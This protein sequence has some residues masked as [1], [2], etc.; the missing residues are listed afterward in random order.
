[1]PP[2]LCCHAAGNP[3]QPS[4][5]DT[6]SP[7]GTSTGAPPIL[8]TDGTLPGSPAIVLHTSLGVSQVP[9]G[10][11]F[12]LQGFLVLDKQAEIAAD[13][14]LNLTIQRWEQEDS[15][16]GF[17]LE[18]VTLAQGSCEQPAAGDAACFVSCHLGQVSLGQPMALYMSLRALA[19]GAQLVVA[20]SITSPG[21]AAVGIPVRFTDGFGVDEEPVHV[22]GDQPSRVFVGASEVLRFT[23]TAPGLSA[24]NSTA[25]IQIDGPGRVVKV[26]A[27]ISGSLMSFEVL[28]APDSAMILHIVAGACVGADGQLSLASEPFPLIVDFSR[29]SVTVTSGISGRL[30][31]NA[32]AVFRI[33]FSERVFGFSEDS[34]EVS[35][36]Y[37]TCLS[38]VNASVGTYEAIVR[39]L[40]GISFLALIVKEGAAIDEAF[41][42]SNSSTANKQNFGSSSARS[43]LA[44]M[45][46]KI[47]LAMVIL[48][49]LTRGGIGQGRLVAFIGHLQFFQMISRLD[50]PLDSNVERTLNSIAWVNHAW[51]QPIFGLGGASDDTTY[52]TFGSSAPDLFFPSNGSC[53]QPPAEPFAVD[54]STDHWHRRRLEDGLFPITLAHLNRLVQ[55]A[56]PPLPAFQPIANDGSD[57]HSDSRAD[58]WAV[59]V[60]CLC[61]LASCL[62]LRALC[63]V[64]WRVMKWL[65]PSPWWEALPAVLIFPRLELLVLMLTYPGMA[66]ACVSYA[67][68]GYKGGML[69]G[70]CIG[71]SYPLAFVAFAAYFLFI[72]IL[73]DK[74]CQFQRERMYL[75][76]AIDRGNN[77]TRNSFDS[78][79]DSDEGGSVSSQMGLEGGKR[80]F[81]IE[82]SWTDCNADQRRDF[83]WQY[84]LLFQDLKGP[85]K[86]MSDVS[87]RYSSG[88]DSRKPRDRVGRP[89]TLPDLPGPDLWRQ[90]ED[91]HRGSG[92]Q[93][94]PM[95]SRT[96]WFSPCSFAYCPALAAKYSVTKGH[97]ASSYTVLVLLKQLAFAAIAGISSRHLGLTHLGWF[98]VI[99]F[100][101]WLFFH[102]GYLMLV[103]PFIL[104]VPNVVEV[105]ATLCEL[106]SM[107]CC[108]GLLITPSLTGLFSLLLVLS[109]GIFALASLLELLYGLPIIMKNCW[110]TAHATLPS[111]LPGPGGPT[112]GG[113]MPPSPSMTYY[114]FQPMASSRSVRLAS[115]SSN[116]QHSRR[117]HGSRHGS[118]SSHGSRV[119]SA[120]EMGFHK[121]AATSPDGTIASMVS[122]GGMIGSGSDAAGPVGL[123][124]S[125]MQLKRKLAVPAALAATQPPTPGKH[126]WHD[127]TQGT[128]T[129]VRSSN[130]PRRSASLDSST[131]SSTRSSLD[132]LLQ[133]PSTRAMAR[134]PA[135]RHDGPTII[136]AHNT[137]ISGAERANRG[138]L[139]SS[140][141]L[142]SKRRASV[143]SLTS[144]ANSSRMSGR[145]SGR[146]SGRWVV[147]AAGNRVYQLSRLSLTINNPGSVEVNSDQEACSPA[148]IHTSTEPS[149]SS[150]GTPKS[151]NSPSGR[152]LS[153]SY[154]LSDAEG[155]GVEGG[156]DSVSTSSPHG[157]WGKPAR[158]FRFSAA[159][160]TQVLRVPSTNTG[161]GDRSP[162]R[163][164]DSEIED[165]PDTYPVLKGEGKSRENRG[166]SRGFRQV[167]PSLPSQPPWDT[168]QQVIQLRDNAGSPDFGHQPV[169]LQSD[170]SP[171]LTLHSYPSQVFLS[172]AVLAS[173]WQLPGAAVEQAQQGEQQRSV[174]GQP[175]R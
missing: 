139:E 69:V 43:K 33:Q 101:I 17:L 9:A 114:V 11:R 105:L 150:R 137:R 67:T 174:T 44:N 123:P 111:W 65:H 120:R 38:P 97:L 118:H 20:A 52:P 23:V 145:T 90:P 152:L 159:L 98:Q 62:A 155:G 104:K 55:E 53:R 167:V 129:N 16:F 128:L 54:A 125:P 27:G 28:T 31:R 6:G 76:S 110:Q 93:W 112:L 13:S 41:N 116:S 133:P 80:P 83:V 7:P 45:F 78:T 169:A 136:G 58:F 115:I 71:V 56:H 68:S 153:P 165:A 51:P 108:L 102:M 164:I 121:G 113:D 75:L 59:A 82:A 140:G 132:I 57:L 18:S 154:S 21:Q 87:S 131:C 130:T 35:G 46:L 42:P 166:A 161:R 2:S 109:I 25:P 64:V 147:D 29:P 66:H 175:S 39:P 8:I 134:D 50:I 73:R 158:T 92:K 37:I 30:P 77:V 89:S 88:G 144:E 91:V 171:A 146:A 61:M 160:G 143:G 84:G 86:D 157:R 26:T 117:N 100:I 34:I 151:Q 148:G 141:L 126:A 81:L 1:M 12:G 72:K 142:T 124:G 127:S 103:Q 135:S 74:E 122:D 95:H 96:V 94:P 14:L 4:I 49:T 170:D 106:T 3:D 107:V 149:G 40:G 22:V 24:C 156:T 168:A 173:R 47:F 32:L 172:P 79:S 119:A 138:S 19:V 48:V 163:A 60:L 10:Y 15:C 36:G 85:S 99:S 162:E 63:A 70:V 5:P